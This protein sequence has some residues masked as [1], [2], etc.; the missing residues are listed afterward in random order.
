MVNFIDVFRKHT[1]I[2]QSMWFEC[3]GCTAIRGCYIQYPIVV[4]VRFPL[5]VQSQRLCKNNR[6]D[7]WTNDFTASGGNLQ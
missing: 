6:R 5:Y 2:H 1:A 7:S 3:G 4:A